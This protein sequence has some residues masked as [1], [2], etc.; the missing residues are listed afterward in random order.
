[1]RG[2]GGSPRRVEQ[3]PQPGDPAGYRGEKSSGEVAVPEGRGAFRE[4]PG[5]R[6]E[7]HRLLVFPEERAGDLH[8][9]VL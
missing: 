3:D 2:L 4:D 6:P 8:V 7:T 1:M 9:L 5:A